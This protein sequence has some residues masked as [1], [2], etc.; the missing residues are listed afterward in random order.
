MIKTSVPVW[1]L[2]AVV[3]VASGLL[4]WAQP[5]RA[6]GS[7]FEVNTTADP[8]TPATAGC[9]GTECTLREAVDAANAD[10]G[11][12]RIAFAPGI[13]GQTINLSTAGGSFY[14]DEYALNVTSQVTIEGPTG[15]ITIARDTGAP[16]MILFLVDGRNGSGNLTL[17]GLTLTNGKA[18]YDGGGINI[19][20]GTV[21][22][23]N[24]NV[25]RNSGRHGGGI[26]NTNVARATLT[27]STVSG[28]SANRAGGIWNGHGAE[29]SDDELTL[30][31]STVSGNTGSPGGIL[32]WYSS[33]ASLGN[34]IVAGNGVDLSAEFEN[35]GSFSSRGHN[36]IGIDE[37]LTG[38]GQAE[39]GLTDGQNGDHVGTEAS[40]LDPRLG[41]LQDNG[42]L[43]KTHELLGD[44]PAIDAGDDTLAASLTTDQR[45]EGFPRK[46]GA[47]VDIGAFEVMQNQ[48][49]AAQDD[50]YEISQDE[51]LTVTAPGVLANDSDPDGDTLI[52]ANVD[53]P[54]SGALALNPDGSL[55]SDSLI[56]DLY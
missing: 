23:E 50:A 24:S 19:F 36:L 8:A 11:A 10:T 2:L 48:S 43:T 40:P 1:V 30:T 46:R 6:E 31:N 18:R 44:S 7:T 26:S 22:L 34:T 32:N 28:N 35:F 12:D 42:G 25:S 29:N 13:A 37:D 16:D 52:A 41:P 17:S 47:H 51:P 33:V 49:P 56:A 54:Q 27:N 45:G 53:D 3:A 21:A 15:G 20:F 5:A 4:L 9:D 55:R 38:D 14:A 39:S